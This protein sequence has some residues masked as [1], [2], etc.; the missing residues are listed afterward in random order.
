M[1]SLNHYSYGSIVEWLYS[2]AA[3][4][5]PMTSAPGFRKFLLAP[6]P[7]RSLGWLEAKYQS[8][9]G[10]IESAWEYDEDG[11]VSF[12]F[13]VPLGAEARIVLPDGQEHEVRGG[14]HHYCIEPAV[15]EEWNMPINELLKKNE[16]SFALKYPDLY[17]MMLFRM[18]AG[19][20]SLS[21]LARE[22]FQIVE[23]RDD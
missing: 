14:E 21:D 5:R 23:K 2:Y 7:D 20:R 1:N 8:P 12:S 22:G 4:I 18:M 13:V 9:T 19:T 16:E 17:G 15:K 3:G 10:N 11:K 6:V